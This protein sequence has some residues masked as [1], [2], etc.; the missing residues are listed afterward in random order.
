MITLSIYQEL[1]DFIRAFRDGHLNMLVVCSRGGLGKSETVQRTMQDHPVFISGHETPLDLYRKLYDGRDRLVVFDEIDGLLSNTANVGL[2][3]QVCETR[4]VKRVQWG[5]TDKRAAKIDGLLANT[6]NVGLL[7]Q[8][9]ETREIKRVQWGST[10]QR[11]AKIDGGVGHFHTRSRVCLLCNSFVLFN[12]NVAALK[13][14]GLAVQFVPSNREILDKIRTFATDSEIIEFLE[15]FHECIPEFSLRTY[16]V[17]QDLKSAGLDWRRYAID[18]TEIPPKVLEIARL[19]ESHDTD[20]ERVERYSGSRRDFYTRKPD[21]VEYRRRQ[22][23]KT[24]KLGVDGSHNQC[25]Q[26]ERLTNAAIDRGTSS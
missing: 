18:E 22:S 13:T 3:K 4:E 14:R 24:L 20:I 8:V 9:C 15:E 25:V 7:K 16:R 6:A 5:S 11:A 21:A 17:L 19:L 2:L 23:I 10:D 12:A 26:E 1:S